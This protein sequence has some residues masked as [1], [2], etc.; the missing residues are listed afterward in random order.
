MPL[1]FGLKRRSNVPRHPCPSSPHHQPPLLLYHSRGGD[2][3]QDSVTF[4]SNSITWVNS[5]VVK[6]NKIQRTQSSSTR[7]PNQRLKTSSGP[8]VKAKLNKPYSHSSREM[9]PSLSASIFSKSIY[10]FNL[11]QKFNT[12]I[13]L[14]S[15]L[16]K[17]DV[18]WN[19]VSNTG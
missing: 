15:H 8:L 13:H 17:Q 5:D 11:E 3:W 6:V 12:V 4:D 18:Y 7:G 19:S 2:S 14:K 16:T 9:H 10:I 1:N